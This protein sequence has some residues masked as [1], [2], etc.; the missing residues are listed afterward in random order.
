[1]EGYSSNMSN[2]LIFCK[3]PHV[4][5]TIGEI[6]RDVAAGLIDVGMNIVFVSTCEPVSYVE[7]VEGMGYPLVVGENTIPCFCGSENVIV[8]LYETMTS[9]KFEYALS[10]GERAEMDMISAAIQVV[11]D[12]IKHFHIWTGS[13]EPSF[14]ISES[15]GR[16][17]KLICFGS[18]AENKFSKLCNCAVGIEVRRFNSGICTKEPRDDGIICGGPCNDVANLLSVAEGLSG[19][20]RVVHILSNIYEPADYDLRSFCDQFDLSVNFGEE[21][22]GTFHGLDNKNLQNLASKHSLVIDLSMKQS[23][24]Y[25]IDCCIQ[26]GCVPVVSRTPRHV[27]FLTSRG[28]SSEYVDLLTV[29]CCKLRP[30]GGD[31]LWVSDFTFLLEKIKLLKDVNTLSSIKDMLMRGTGMLP[32][33][34]EEIYKFFP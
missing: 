14:S 19:C 7:S 5:G 16:L 30:S 34:R 12:G 22:Y 24:C 31:C 21:P 9:N 18:S 26:S 15:L 23:C 13:S 33:M 32:S 6:C 17:D 29:P 10:I 3:S 8:S 1:M 27:N 20:G 25:A 28:L 4:A 2:V 11:G